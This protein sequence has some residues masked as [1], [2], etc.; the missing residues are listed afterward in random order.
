MSL[1]QGLL[2]AATDL[3]WARAMAMSSD[4]WCA[5]QQ[6]LITRLRTLLQLLQQQQQGAACPELANQLSP[7]QRSAFA[8]AVLSGEGAAAA[9]AAADS[10]LEPE[11]EMV[12][13]I[14]DFNTLV[15]NTYSMR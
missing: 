14:D 1:L 8:A 3:D 15:R 13:L 11:V 4:D 10:V 12:A 5:Y 7:A 6:R 9:A 2:Q